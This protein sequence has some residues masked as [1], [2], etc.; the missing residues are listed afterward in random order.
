[1]NLDRLG[2]RN[3]FDLLEDA[4]GA[5]ALAEKLGAKIARKSDGVP[6][7]IFEMI[8]GLK[9]GRLIA[10]QPDGT[11][12]QTQVI[13][14]IE[15]P[16]AVKDLIEG[17]MRDLSPDQRAILDAG[18]VCG[19]RFDPAL[20]ANVVE[21][22]RVRVLR[23]LAE[24]ERR[25]GLVRGEEDHV[26]FDQNQV[27]EVL[28]GDLM[29]DLRREYHTLLAEAH[30]ARC[31]ANPAGDDAVFLV[32]HDLRGNRPQH[33]LPRLEA[34]LDHLNQGY[35][36]DAL[37][38]LAERALR[39]DGLLDG[40]DRARVLLRLS[41]HL[42][43]LGRREE[44]RTALDEAV[45]LADACGDEALRA[46]AWRA[47]AA[48]WIALSESDAAKDAI[49]RAL[50]L[51]RAA[52]DEHVELSAI[53]A[54]GNLSLH[55]GRHAEAQ[56]HLDEALALSRRIESRQ[57][58]ANIT[59]H[60]GN[61][62]YALG[63][64]AEAEEYYQR[65][66]D[67]SHA[68]EDR[69]GESIAAGNLGA[70]LGNAG[71][72]AAAQEQFERN[73]AL[74][75]EI[76]YRPGEALA[77]ECLGGIQ[78]SLGHREESRGLH[79]RARALCREVGDRNLEGYALGSLGFL[80][81]TGADLDTAERY[82]EE[83]LALRREIGAVAGIA[84]MLTS[85]GRVAA[86]REDTDTAVS[87]VDE[88]LALAHECRNPGTILT[89]TI[90]RAGLPGGDVDG[91]VA[92]LADHEAGLEHGVKMKAR[93]RLWELTG[94]RAH[95]DEAHR[96]LAFMR[97]HAPDEDRD[98]MIENVPLHSDIMSAWAQHARD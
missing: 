49:D 76:G 44:Q 68:L 47:R 1:M 78:R 29:P 55:L 14:D 10:K 83:A 23:N 5:E 27:Q 70:I 60:I 80:A 52:G 58:E 81:E 86:A 35:R 50:V 59:C 67:L 33:A 95:L 46:R 22:K 66:R 8:R 4:F 28:Y 18:A 3:I 54:L 34:A 45:A 98:S 17:R 94:D 2:A 24:I 32:H 30:A 84:D 96:L 9:D 82:Y 48:L 43:H 75:R 93:Y 57:S 90:A 89:A 61:V 19:V 73:R 63:R 21:E 79:E 26:R 53:G 41:D 38:D 42:E 7:F 51:A 97:D 77:T 39:A 16:S 31:G 65:Y 87:R 71:R 91:A 56:A 6:F 62:V 85:L 15:V 12:A 20:I 92:V 40:V 37:L 88:A 11:Y 25:H 13:D 64:Y 69:R 36:N 74:S 72:C